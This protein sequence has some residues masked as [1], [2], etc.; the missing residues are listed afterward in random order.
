MT[1]PV[2]NMQSYLLQISCFKVAN[3]KSFSQAHGTPI[4]YGRV[5]PRFYSVTRRSRACGRPFLREQRGF[6]EGLRC[7]AP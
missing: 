7:G 5:L 2:S 4:V 1:F 3:L 6:G